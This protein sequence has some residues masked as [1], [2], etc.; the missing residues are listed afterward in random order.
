MPSCCAGNRRLSTEDQPVAYDLAR[1]APHRLDGKSVR[2]D[3]ERGIRGNEIAKMALQ[4]RW[5][6]RVDL[7][8]SNG[9]SVRRVINAG[10]TYVGPD[11]IDVGNR[12]LSGT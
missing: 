1:A 6:G 11:D 4:G 5:R 2:D 10:G 3:C 7:A 12:K 9:K 8:K